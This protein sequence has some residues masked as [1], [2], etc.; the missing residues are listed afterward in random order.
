MGR[1]P[2][3]EEYANPTTFYNLTG[4]QQ[5][6]IVRWCLDRF[7][8]AKRIC[9]M[10]SYE[11]KHI[12]ERDSN[13]FYVTDGQFVGA[14]MKAGFVP[15]NAK[16]SKKLLHFPAAK[17]EGYLWFKIKA[18][19]PCFGRLRSSG[20]GSYPCWHEP[21]IRTGLCAYH[22]GRDAWGLSL[23]PVQYE[24]REERIASLEKKGR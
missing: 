3:P 1:Y 5:E 16:Q 7:A 17:R 8:P 12:F 24:T 11:L 14:M 18:A 23:N 6:N 21:D 22:R 10:T 9:E 2:T 20:Y 13:G 19:K 4:D 15:L